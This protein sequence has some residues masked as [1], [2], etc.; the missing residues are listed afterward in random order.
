MTAATLTQ[1]RARAAARSA[2]SSPRTVSPHVFLPEETPPPIQCVTFIIRYSVALS[3]TCGWRC[4]AGVPR[5]SCARR[6]SATCSCAPGATERSC[7]WQVTYSL[8]R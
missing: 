4:R 3:R 2:L 5:A 8:R 1:P 6:R 7:G